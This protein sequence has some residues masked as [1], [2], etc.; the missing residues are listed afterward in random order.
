[1]AAFRA[2]DLDKVKQSSS[3]FGSFPATSKWPGADFTVCQ[4]SFRQDSVLGSEVIEKL[5]SL[6]G[7]VRK[8]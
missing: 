8:V 2:F 4:N 6:L 7:Q 3:D 1:M 5:A